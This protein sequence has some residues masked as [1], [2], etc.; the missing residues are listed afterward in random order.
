MAGG[1]RKPDNQ[2]NMHRDGNG[3]LTVDEML[4]E[5]SQSDLFGMNY[6]D[7]LTRLQTDMIP[8]AGINGVPV[9]IGSTSIPDGSTFT[10]DA[11]SGA[12]IVT[13]APVVTPW[14]LLGGYNNGWTNFGSGF[15]AGAWR[16]DE[17]GMI[18]FRGVLGTTGA[19]GTVAITMSAGQRIGQH[20]FFTLGGGGA[21][22]AINAGVD[23]SGPITI[24]YGS[25]SNIAALDGISYLV[26]G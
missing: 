16:I 10:Y 19:S 7:L 14:T 5:A 6:V 13:A 1:G 17:T 24:F 22:L 15:P 20:G 23:P 11:S 3:G 4:G 25:G 18:H 2:V 12:Y 9:D 26:E 21:N 8:T